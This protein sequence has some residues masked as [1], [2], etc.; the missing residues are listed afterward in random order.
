MIIKVNSTEI[1]FD[2]SIDKFKDIFFHIGGLEF[3]GILKKNTPKDTGHLHSAWHM[4]QKGNK[5]RYT[6]SAKYAGWVNEG[7]GIYGVKRKRITPK[8]RK[9]LV[10]S[11]GKKFSGK[12]GKTTNGKYFFRSVKGQKGQHY[13]EKSTEKIKQRIPTIM[14]NV[15]QLTFKK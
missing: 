14:Q 8:S 12:Y 1:N 5:I 6:N 3:L 15:T 7:T 11:P 4:E 2:G 9:I 10:F 13:V